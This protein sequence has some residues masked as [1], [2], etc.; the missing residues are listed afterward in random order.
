MVAASFYIFLFSQLLSC[1]V[2]DGILL[3][4]FTDFVPP[5]DSQRARPGKNNESGILKTSPRCLIISAPRM[6]LRVC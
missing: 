4:L 3:P 2:S 6:D 5:D 1:V